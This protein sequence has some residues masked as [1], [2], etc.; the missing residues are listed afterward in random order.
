[1]NPGAAIATEGTNGVIVR[2][3]MLTA[4]DLEYTWLLLGLLAFV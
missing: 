3:T 2:T 1:M 4:D